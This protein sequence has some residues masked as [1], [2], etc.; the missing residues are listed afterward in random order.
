[1]VMTEVQKHNFYVSKVKSILPSK[2][3]RAVDSESNEVTTSKNQIIGSS[4]ESVSDMCFDFKTESLLD[5][6]NESVK[7]KV[8]IESQPAL[9]N[10]IIDLI[11]E[12]QTFDSSENKFSICVPKSAINDERMPRNAPIN[13]IFTVFFETEGLDTTVNIVYKVAF[14]N[15]IVPSLQFYKSVLDIDSGFA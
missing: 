12:S 9:P 15:E 10:D 6:C 1:M 3:Y 13:L 4:P 8:F 7:S 11:N 2:C 5:G 14:A